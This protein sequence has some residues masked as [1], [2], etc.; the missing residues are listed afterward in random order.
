MAI[1]STFLVKVNGDV[2]CHQDGNKGKGYGISQFGN[3]EPDQPWNFLIQKFR[4][5]L[6]TSP[7]AL[8]IHWCFLPSS[9]ITY[10]LFSFWTCFDSFL[11]SA[12]SAWGIWISME[13][14]YTVDLSWGWTNSSQFENRIQFDDSA[15]TSHDM[16]TTMVPVDSACQIGLDSR[17]RE[18]LTIVGGSSWGRKKSSR[19]PDKRRYFWW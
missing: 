12:W 7:P 15:P 19:F 1:S 18:D 14:L 3:F 2:T 5:G 16:A 17:L 11:G 10:S 6:T 9:I 13:R 4:T 8:E